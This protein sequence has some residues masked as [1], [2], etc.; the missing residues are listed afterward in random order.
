MS[1]E[2]R[3]VTVLAIASGGGHWLQLSRLAPAWA[4][5]RVVSAC[6]AEAPPLPGGALSHHRLRDATRWNPRDALV[7]GAQVAVLILKAR[8]D[9]VVTTGALPGLFGV[10]WGR[11]IGAHTVWI[12][13]V[14]NVRRVSGSGR[15]AGL[16]AHEW[17]TQWPHLS[18]GQREPS[19][20]KHPLRR[21][22]DYR[23]SIW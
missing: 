20:R 23:G 18:P 19:T 6:A 13:S 10:L 22:P 21:R 7:L 9:I 3:P 11:L 16:I 8:P 15:I 2:S 12:D 1:P 5:C 17:W 14:A 4:G